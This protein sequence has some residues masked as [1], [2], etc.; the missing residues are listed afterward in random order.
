MRTNI[1]LDDHLLQEVMRD[2]HFNTKK[3]AVHQALKLMRRM[4]AQQKVRE[5]RG[6][7]TSWEGNLDES[8]QS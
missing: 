3:E 1:D 2:G 4:Q 6:K 7:L 8:R 5:M